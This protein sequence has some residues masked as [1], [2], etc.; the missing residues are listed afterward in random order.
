MAINIVGCRRQW[1]DNRGTVK[2]HLQLD[3]KS[4]LYTN[5][6]AAVAAA[7]LD[8]VQNA[9]YELHTTKIFT[10]S[11]FYRWRHTAQSS[12]SQRYTLV[13]HWNGRHIIITRP[14][15]LAGGSCH[16]WLA[17]IQS[18][19]NVHRNWIVFDGY[20]Y[21]VANE[22]IIKKRCWNCVTFVRFVITFSE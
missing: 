7:V 11:G 18:I 1:D 16:G 5:A 6:A 13:E 19:I 4:T 3:S 8:A 15:C 14:F 12:H 21:R 22:I 2:T 10:H 20:T 9:I 17:L